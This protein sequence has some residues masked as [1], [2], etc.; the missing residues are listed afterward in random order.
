MINKISIYNKNV[1]RIKMSCIDEEG[2]LILTNKT[3]ITDDILDKIKKIV[4]DESLQGIVFNNIFE[5]DSK[6]TYDLINL[7]EVDFCNYTFHKMYECSFFNCKKIKGIELPFT[8]KILD[9]GCF[10]NCSLLESIILHGVKKINSCAFSGCI[11]LKY[12]FISD[13]IKEIDETAFINIPKEQDIKIICPDGF[14]D[15]FKER[16]PNASINENE[17]VLK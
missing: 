13:E 17:F 2:T 12:L 4:I 7:E 9:W 14:Y 1:K 10:A 3:K 16:F 15:Y 8:I 11:S 6:N 5:N